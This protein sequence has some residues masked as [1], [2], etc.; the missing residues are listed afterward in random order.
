MLRAVRIVL[1]VVAA[2]SLCALAAQTANPDQSN[3]GWITP[4]IKGYGQMVPLPNAAVQPDKNRT[5]KMVFLI[6]KAADDPKEVSDGVDHLA[7]IYNVFES[8]GVPP[9][10]LKIVAVFTGAAS[11]AAMNNDVYR[12]KYKQDN[13]NLKALQELK[14][15]GAELYVC[16]QAMHFLRLDEKQLSP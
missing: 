9:K 13:P 1:L 11:Y 5:Y 7:R 12:E 2:G 15:A 6:E 10:N 3:G 16:G 14:E 8:L 4:V